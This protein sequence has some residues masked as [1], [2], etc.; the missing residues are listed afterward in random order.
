VAERAGAREPP[1]FDHH[2]LDPRT[3]L[4]VRR[5]PLRLRTPLKVLG[6]FHKGAP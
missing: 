5:P 6:P 1:S 2:G 3:E 4:L